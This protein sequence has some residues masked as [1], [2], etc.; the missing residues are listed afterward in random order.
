MFVGHR[1][2]TDPDELDTLWARLPKDAERIEVVME[3]TRNA[4]VALA[5]WFRRHGATV[6]MVPP[7]QSADLRD[8]YNKHTKTD[9][10]DSKVLARLPLLHPEGLHR[11]DSLG[12]G[13]E[14]KRAVK[15]RSGLV[16]RRTAC[17][18]RLD[19]LLEILGP[20]WIAA[21]GSDMTLTALRF[22]ARYA[23]PVQVKRLGKARLAAF[24]RRSSRQAWAD[25]RADAVIEAAATT[26]RLWG[27]D[28]GE[29]DFDALGADIAAE[30]RLALTLT[31]E[32]NGFD[33]RIG[34]LYDK[35]DPAGIVRSV[36][37]AG[38]VCA[39]QIL[40][41]L[42]DPTR[43]ANLAAVRSFAGL[44]PP[45]TPPAKPTATADRPRPAIAACARPCSSPPT[46]PAR[47]TPPWPSA[48][49][50][51]CSP[52]STTI[53]RSARWLR[54]CSPESPP[55]CAPAPTTYCA[56]PTA[57]S[58]PKPKDAPSSPNA[59]PC[60][61]RSVPPGA[62]SPPTDTHDATSGTSVPRQ[63]SPRAP[64]HRP[65][66]NQHEPPTAFVATLD[67]G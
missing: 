20:A 60:H 55:V 49:S 66:R 53:P 64:R 4:W 21:L 54:S 26:L 59:T 50:G 31:D 32:I 56:T 41:R 36:P 47:S 24:F 1:F 12:P 62:R 58:S 3:P 40:G 34:A 17:M 30:A 39:P 45:P 6:V 33:K 10:L 13:D 67:I 51:S 27:A 11:E 42:G 8:Y 35:A 38:R 44:V 61:P 52:V 28:G 25:E 18:A 43:F 9:R 29:L 16:H 48:T 19:A 7:E 57:A 65:F 46:T 2:R 37:G 15:I 23:N 63:E 5:A 22:L 14:L